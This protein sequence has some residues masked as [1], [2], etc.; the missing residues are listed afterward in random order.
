VIDVST[1]GMMLLTATTW[2][3]VRNVD[4]RVLIEENRVLRQR[5]GRRRL[6]FTD[7]DLRKLVA[8]GLPGR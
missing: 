8:W 5:V 4:A 7:E 3:D 6:Q 2:L 1:L